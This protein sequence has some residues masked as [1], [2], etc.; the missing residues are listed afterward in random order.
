MAWDGRKTEGCGCGQILAVLPVAGSP[1]EHFAALLPLF[2]LK[3][4]ADG[5][6]VEPIGP[7]FTKPDLRILRFQGRVGVAQILATAVVSADL[8][9][10]VSDGL[11]LRLV[12]LVCEGF[13]IGF[14]NLPGQFELHADQ[15]ETARPEVHRGEGV[16]LPQV[17]VSRARLGK[18]H[19]GAFGVQA[20]LLRHRQQLCR[21]ILPLG[22]PGI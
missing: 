5:D 4:V 7:V 8:T 14:G 12:V 9:E 16:S 18:Q 15:V 22:A 1:L 10:A 2:D 21:H 3:V 13:G 20:Q 11:P 6:V 17:R 19:D